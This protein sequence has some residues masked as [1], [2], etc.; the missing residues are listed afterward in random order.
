L[1]AVR[2]TVTL[3]EQLN[4]KYANTNEL[5]E[6]TAVPARTIAHIGLIIRKKPAFSLSLSQKKNSTTGRNPS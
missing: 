5:S 2:V 6:A 1:L 4:E 3:R